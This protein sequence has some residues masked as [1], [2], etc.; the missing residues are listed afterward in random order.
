MLLEAVLDGSLAPGD[1]IPHIS[2]LAEIMGT[3]A[4]PINDAW[5]LAR[6]RGLVSGKP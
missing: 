6:E 5:R 2:V 4:P 3:S 1:Q